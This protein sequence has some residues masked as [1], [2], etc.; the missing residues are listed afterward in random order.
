MRFKAVFAA[1]LL[2]VLLTACHPTTGSNNP[3]ML[4][5]TRT[6]TL[7]GY[8]F[9]PLDV[10]I[11][12][13]TTVQHIYQ[14]AYAQPVPP[15]G[16]YNCPVDIGLIYHLDFFQD[17]ASVEQ[18]SLNATGCQFLQITHDDVRMSSEAFRE[19]LRKNLGIPSLVPPI[20]GRGQP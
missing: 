7:P 16:I 4:R 2:L 19:L 13:V 8:N 11:R 9:A 1:S 10:T 6:E 17:G 14:A 20:P 12:N 15:S 5:V 3:T 18:M